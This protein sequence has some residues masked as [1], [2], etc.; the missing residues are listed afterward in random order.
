MRGR[1]E[2][3]SA[4]IIGIG[5]LAVTSRRWSGP[6]LASA[7]A[8]GLFIGVAFG[9]AIDSLG[10]SG[11]QVVEIPAPESVQTASSTQPSAPGGG[12]STQTSNSSPSL[13]PAPTPYPAPAPYA[14]PPPLP[15]PE[16]PPPSS[17]DP[18]PTPPHHDP[19]PAGYAGTVVHVNPLAKSYTL[20]VR[21]ELYGVHARD[22]PKP[23]QKIEVPL[24]QLANGT[25]AEDGDRVSS[26]STSRGTLNGFVTWVSEDR[27]T[28]GYTVS[29]R[30]SS[31]P[32]TT[33]DGTSTS[34]L[35]KLGTFVSVD[36]SI[37]DPP[38]PPPAQEER[39]RLG[40]VLDAVSVPDPTVPVLPDPDPTDPAADPPSDSS[41]TREEPVKPIEAQEQLVQ[42]K[43]EPSGDPFGYFDLAGS[44]QAVCPDT[45]QLLL[46]SDDIRAAGVDVTL[47]VPKGI[48]LSKVEVDSPVLATAE[49]GKDDGLT[50][51]GIAG[52]AGAD[53]ADDDSSF[54][55]DFAG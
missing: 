17:P 54:Q 48:D 51:A 12:S 31:V 33:P 55:G 36:V 21:G 14:P 3:L 47:A 38:P 40:A 7:L 52:D 44:V 26:G 24:R 46:S 50:L 2:S 6:L 25:F 11:P 18:G 27:E 16:E 29:V 13:A 19:D 28:P 22:L 10:A 8:M 53:D 45:D 9:P 15:P 35:P 49:V 34:D 1:V 20:A 23:G 5:T 37:E 41:C 43:V 4:A 32:I 30:G 42:R 39:T